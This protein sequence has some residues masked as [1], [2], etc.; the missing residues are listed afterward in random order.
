M[1]PSGH[2]TTHVSMRSHHVAR[3]GIYPLSASLESTL[4]YLDQLSDRSI[5][6]VIGILTSNGTDTAQSHIPVVVN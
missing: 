3:H 6:D 1:T 4:L 5:N 2:F